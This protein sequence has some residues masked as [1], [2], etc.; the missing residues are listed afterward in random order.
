M[1]LGF[2]SR[3]FGKQEFVKDEDI[4]DFIRSKFGISQKSTPHVVILSRSSVNKDANPIWKWFAE[5]AEGSPRE[6]RWNFATKFVVGRNGKEVLRFD[7]KV[8]PMD[9]KDQIET[10]LNVPKTEEGSSNL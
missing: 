3:E 10:F 8:N 9:L 7:G 6:T 1:I 2:P 4:S 5:K